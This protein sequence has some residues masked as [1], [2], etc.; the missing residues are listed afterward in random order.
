MRLYS[1]N[2]SLAARLLLLTNPVAMTTEV[3]VRLLLKTTGLARS[4]RE[5]QV[6]LM[7]LWKEPPAKS[8]SS[9]WFTDRVA[10]AMKFAIVIASRR[11]GHRQ[12]QATT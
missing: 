9:D 12:P 11:H 8:H 5:G 4:E 3:D 10:R 1:Y 7:R 6:G 2:E